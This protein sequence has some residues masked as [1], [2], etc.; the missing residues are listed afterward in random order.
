[1][2][3]PATAAAIVILLLS[4]YRSIPFQGNQLKIKRLMLL[5]FIN[6]IILLAIMSLLAFLLY[7]SIEV[8]QQITTLDELFV[9]VGFVIFIIIAR[10]VNKR[11]FRTKKDSPSI[12]PTA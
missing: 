2:L 4:I 11:V 12:T 1:M 10:L 7:L 5:S 6:T 9:I 3:F 8:S